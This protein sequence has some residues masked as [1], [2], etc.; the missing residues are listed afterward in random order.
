MVAR[1]SLPFPQALY[2][3]VLFYLFVVLFSVKQISL[4][5]FLAGPVSVV[6][7]YKVSCKVL[8]FV[9][10]SLSLALKRSL[11]MFLLNCMAFNDT[12]MPSTLISQLDSKLPYPTA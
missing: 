12:F 6:K 8:F 4:A 5:N 7:F 11:Q 1:Q 9:F 3:L 10:L 2:S